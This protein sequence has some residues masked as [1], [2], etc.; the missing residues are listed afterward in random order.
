MGDYSVTYE[1][2][3]VHPKKPLWYYKIHFKN[4]NGKDQFT[5]TPN[6][7]VNYKG[8]QGLMANPDAKHFWS[9]DIFVYITSLPDPEK[10]KDTTGFNEKLMSPGDTIFYSKG[11]AVLKQVKLNDKNPRYDFSSTDTAL[12]ATFT[13]YG[14]DSS[15]HTAQPI[16]WV[17]ER[18]IDLTPDTVLAQNIVLKLDGVEETKVKVGI[19]ES[20]NVLQFVTLKAYK[21]PFINL[22]WAG[23]LIMVIGLIISMARRIQ[24]NK[25]SHEIDNLNL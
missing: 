13:V 20:G 15:I 3:S 9:H 2:D 16:L 7:F 19:R 14:M 17:K 10:I 4:K 22:L 5:L 23:T 25:A 11:F 8:N 12:V 18:K 24:L 6:A 1:E 21:F